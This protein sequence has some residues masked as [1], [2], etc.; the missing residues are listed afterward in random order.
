MMM[1]R[2]YQ[3][4]V[5]LLL[6]LCIFCTAAATTASNKEVVQVG[7]DSGM[8]TILDDDPSSHR[9][10][11]HQHLRRL[12]D[13]I[14]RVVNLPQQ[15]TGLVKAF[16]DNHGFDPHGL[17]GTGRDRV[18]SFLWSLGQSLG[19]LQ[20]YIGTEQGEYFTYFNTEAVYRE[21][22]NSGYDPSDPEMNKYYNICVD[23]ANG[24]T[25][26]CTMSEGSSYVYCDDG[27]GDGQCQQEEQNL[28]PCSDGINWC[29]DYTIRQVQPGENLG[30]VPVSYHCIDEH[31][32]FTQ[33]PGQVLNA[34]SEG[35][36]LT[37]HYLGDCKYWDKSIV[38]GSTFGEFAACGGNGES[39]YTA[40]EGLQ[41]TID[42][43]PRVRPWYVTTKE[44]QTENWGEP[45][46]FANEFRDVLGITYANPYYTETEDGKSVFAGVFAVD[47]SFD[48]IARFL[49]ETNVNDD[50]FVMVFEA[51]GP[52]HYL[53]GSSTY[54]NENS[55]WHDVK[56]EDLSTPCDIDGQEECTKVRVSAMD[57]DFA[58]TNRLHSVASR[59][60]HQHANL[61]F[62][63]LQ[64]I[65]VKEDEDDV[66]STTYISQTITYTQENLHWI[67]MTMAPV[68]RSNA[69]TV[70]RGGVSFVALIL[71]ATFGCLACSAFLLLLYFNR[72]KR[73]VMEG[74]VCLT[75]AFIAGCAAM[76]VAAFTMLG[77]NNDHMCMLRSWSINMT[78]SFAMAALLAKV[79][80]LYQLVG[81]A[82]NFRRKT[83]DTKKAAL[84]AV[85]IVACELIILSIFSIVDPPRAMEFIAFDSAGE[86]TQY[87]Q[88]AHRSDAFF[89]TNTVFYAVAILVG[90]VFSYLT[91]N[92]DS[93]YGEA[94]QLFFAMYNVA[95]TGI[96]LLVLETTAVVSP[97]VLKMMRTIG[98]FWA[99]FV[100]SA[101]FV[102]PRLL[103]GPPRR[104][105]STLMGPISG[106]NL[107][108]LNN[109]ARDSSFGM[110]NESIRHRS[111]RVGRSNSS[112]S[113]EEIN[114]NMEE[115]QPDSAPGTREGDSSDSHSQDNAPDDVES[116]IVEF[117]YPEEGNK[118]EAEP[119]EAQ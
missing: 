14:D 53:I 23:R 16:H 1:I 104:Q 77:E 43:D 114:D 69:D 10:D 98:I 47:Y 103:Q 51:A 36:E 112:S 99:T 28:V 86:P 62:P 79:N 74:D 30:Y 71:V 34:L 96:I 21:P 68:P 84:W 8:S 117:S 113:V 95:F 106:L 5:Q 20:V 9:A 19:G 29:V 44:K 11:D 50:A 82:D 102:L 87:V 22:G 90:C 116:V 72:T 105:S 39:C 61:E 115:S 63:S 78:F 91:R 76:N 70:Q 58:G 67:V 54:E 31:G 56:T 3:L 65:F 81:S 45:Y 97:E 24:E 75:S 6:L 55:Y 109:A 17:H 60:A 83:I 46:A 89:Y 13:S 108:E 111:R 100:S 12:V 118:D 52:H 41:G 26:N 38:N 40:Y 2:F 66:D 48:Q 101:V 94:K 27:D 18:M 35:T 73:S 7:S 107:D 32:V 37:S 33:T 42:Y 92:I 4:L 93:R 88:C 85:P 57:L 80:R 59:A 49:R 119:I 64:T 15:A 110:R 25:N